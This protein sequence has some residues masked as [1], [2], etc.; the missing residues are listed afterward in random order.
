MHY[1]E[2]TRLLREAAIKAQAD[3]ENERQLTLIAI[4]HREIAMNDAVKH[5]IIDHFAEADQQVE[6]RER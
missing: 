5:L 2:E 3:V 6:E 4:A 1:D